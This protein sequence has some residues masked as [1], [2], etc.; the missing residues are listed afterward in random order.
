MP[1][2]LSVRHTSEISQT[3]IGYRPIYVYTYTRCEDAHTNQNQKNLHFLSCTVSHRETIS[4]DV[5]DAYRCNQVNHFIASMCQ[6][7]I[8]NISHKLM[9]TPS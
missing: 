2:K 6:V 3:Q 9:C 7:V 1:E 8:V 4:L 5:F